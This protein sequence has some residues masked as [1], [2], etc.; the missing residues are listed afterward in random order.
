[1]KRLWLN[2]R[3]FW[4]GAVL[5]YIGMFHWLRPSMYFSSK[6]VGPIWQ[7]MF[8]TFLGTYA[9]GEDTADFY[10]IGNA[11]QLVGI[12]GI[13][14]VTMSIAGD[15]YNGTLPYLFA[16]PANRLVMFSGRAVVHIF[17]GMIGV[18]I[19]LAWGVAVLGLDLSQANP[20]GLLLVILTV[21]FSTS[22]L[23]LLMGSLSL[24]TVNVM[25][26]NNLIYYLM[27]VLC[28]VNIPVD[29]LPAWVQPISS[30]LPLT[31]G[32]QAAREL[33]TGQALS[34]VLPDIGIE[35]ALGLVYGLAG[36]FVFRWIEMQAKRRATL[37][38]V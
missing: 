25:L 15:R 35:I 13:Y 34:H 8:F 33:V 36:F 24:I 32:L 7:V 3:L 26:V 5:S 6:V 30:I 4:Q 10:I 27:L 11:M 14:G 19:G 31:H 38:A 22:G 28:G 21:A 9:T 23:G 18:L 1:M 12:N 37:E 20:A 16:S 29:R 17:D 2:V